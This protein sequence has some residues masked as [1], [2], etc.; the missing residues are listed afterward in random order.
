MINAEELIKYFSDAVE[1]EEDE[2][3]EQ[4][5]ARDEIKKLRK[6]GFPLAIGSLGLLAG[7]NATNRKEKSNPGSAK[8]VEKLLEEAK[9]KNLIDESLLDSDNDSSIK[10]NSFLDDFKKLIL[11]GPGYNPVHDQL[12]NVDKN[13]A[14]S[15]I[16]HELGHRHFY[17]DEDANPIARKLH[18]LRNGVDPRKEKSIEGRIKQGIN[19]QLIKSGIIGGSG[20]ISGMRR[21][22][23]ESKGKK[24][25]KLNKYLPYALAAVT[26]IPEVG[27]EI[28]ASVHGYNKLKS[29][30]ASKEELR[31]AR[32][33]LGL[34]GGTYLLG[35]GS[36]MLGA[37]IVRG[38]GYGIGKRIFK[39]K[40]KEEE[41]SEEDTK[42]K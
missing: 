5:S 29:L 12:L 32:N 20:L 13:L 21:A 40:K 37:G 15:N 39:K 23:S 8:L 7:L 11:N 14:P 27:S 42:Q 38:V 33:G 22:K 17:N 25:S 16:A 35:A 30:G 31:D 41:K 24:E 19:N 1:K 28:A 10:K 4:P 34:A 2:V 36:K 18:N 9:S 6:K 3:G 26:E